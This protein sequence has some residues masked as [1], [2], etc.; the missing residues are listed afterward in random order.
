MSNVEFT[1]HQSDVASWYRKADVFVLSSAV[2]GSSNAL[3]EAMASG[4]CPVVTRVGGNVDIIQDGV[5]GLLVEPNDVAGL[6]SA[7]KRVLEDSNFRQRLAAA[8]RRSVETD[9]DLA[10]VA[11]WYLK[12][13]DALVTE[14]GSSSRASE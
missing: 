8:A 1:D 5:N 11:L 4:L 9:H 14:H 7:L 2:E 13:F 3:L 12:I 10:R 6:A